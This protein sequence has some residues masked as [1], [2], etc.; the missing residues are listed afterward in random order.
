MTYIE[1]KT[2]HGKKYKY[3]RKS[4]REG[5]KIRHITIK[6]LGPIH[7]IYKT[8]KTR[9]TNASI[10]VRSLQQEEI[11]ILKKTSR[12]N[13][14]FVK[15][16]TKILLLSSKG[17]TAK[18]ISERIGCEI[19]KARKTIKAFNKTGLKSLKR[20]KAKG[21]KPRF[22]KT[23]KAEILQIVSTNPTILGL[24]YTTWSLR[25]LK[26]HLINQNIVDYISI[27]TIREILKSEKMKIKK[28]KRFQ[29]SNDPDFAKKNYK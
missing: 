24:P 5:N 26:K 27:Y 10:Y 11:K 2:I 1:I 16:R 20:G 15:D 13:D 9:K 29:Y 18:E 25:K 7:P 4:I 6:C 12:S 14:A 22:T 3:L 21:A 8:G 17:Y 23:Q 19:R 28:S